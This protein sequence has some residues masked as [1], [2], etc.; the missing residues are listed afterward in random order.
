MFDKSQQLIL[1]QRERN[2]S[3]VNRSHIFFGLV[4][5]SDKSLKGNREDQG[6]G[7]ASLG[8]GS[9][10]NVP[11]LQ[12]SALLWQTSAQRSS[13]KGSFLVVVV[14]SLITHSVSS[15]GIIWLFLICG[16]ALLSPP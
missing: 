12:I 3:P 8:V 5:S 15:G 10:E 13:S 11:L 2:E 16:N 7:T 1:G 9:R 6:P 14:V 4:T